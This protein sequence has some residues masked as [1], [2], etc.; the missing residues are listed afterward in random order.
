MRR[1]KRRK[2]RKSSRTRRRRTENIRRK[3]IGQGEKDR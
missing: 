2:T 3:V 1:T